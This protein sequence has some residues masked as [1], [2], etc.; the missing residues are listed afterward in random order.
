[1]N[2]EDRAYV[3]VPFDTVPVE[4]RRAAP[5]HDAALTRRV[6]FVVE[7]S[8]LTPLFVGASA[9]VYVGRRDR[10]SD[11]PL[12]RQPFSRDASGTLLLPGSGVK[13]ML[14]AAAEALW[15]GCVSMTEV[16]VP[17]AVRRCTG[18]D[19]GYCPCCRLMGSAAPRYAA[20]LRVGSFRADSGAPPR[21]LHIP[22]RY[23]PRSR[24]V[25]DEDGVAA[26]RK[27]Y[28]HLPLSQAW[29]TEVEE[30]EAAPSGQTFVG[31]ILV[32]A[33]ERDEL[34]DLAFLLALPDGYALKLG[35]GK[36]HGLGSVRLSIRSAQTATG[37][38]ADL[39][40]W[41]ARGT[42]R[43]E[44]VHAARWQKLQAVWRY[45]ASGASA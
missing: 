1:M 26:G 6:R 20:R 41:Q 22:R 14:R 38:A 23:P 35:G 10:T 32:D 33:G 39:A 2:G 43:A 21:P 16:P 31:N 30:L 13:G 8:T 28:R 5:H 34:A 3:V 27:F 17:A 36:A 29:G 18:A 25:T 11:R 12:D 7:I 44:T 19:A 15:H 40:A 24:P 42:E 45:P 37:H 4:R 9:D